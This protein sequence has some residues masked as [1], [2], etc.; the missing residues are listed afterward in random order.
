[1]SKLVLVLQ[2]FASTLS[3]EERQAEAAGAAADGLRA[4]V[5]TM[6]SE[7]GSLQEADRQLR[8]TSSAQKTQCDV[9]RASLAKAEKGARDIA[10]DMFLVNSF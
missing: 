3:P 8:M 5:A 6:R 4:E 10:S 7:L 2:H 1:M 9:L